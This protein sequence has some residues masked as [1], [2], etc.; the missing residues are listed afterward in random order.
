MPYVNIKI[1]KCDATAEQKA[2]VIRGVTD[3]L[4]KEFGKNPAHVLVVIEE[5]DTDNLGLGGNSLT[6]LRGP[7]A[8]R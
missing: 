1:A 7:A 5:L 3:L 6:E 2:R 4:A 8:K